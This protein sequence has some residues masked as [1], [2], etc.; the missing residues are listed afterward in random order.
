MTFEFGS[1]E[2]IKSLGEYL[3]GR[4]QEKDLS[5]EEVAEKIK[6]HVKYLAA[7]E[8]GKDADLPGPVYKE[9]FLK[10]YCEFL[11]V[12]IDELTLR[13]PEQEPIPEEE[14]DVEQKETVKERPR[15]AAAAPVV[16]EPAAQKNSGGRTFLVATLVVL[17]IVLAV[18][19]VQVYRGELFSKEPVQLPP[20]REKMP[21]PEPVINDS[22]V[23]DTSLSLPAAQEMI[24]LLMVGRGECWVE[25]SIDGDS[26]FSE[27]MKTQDTLWLAMQ[28]SIIF[29]LGRANSVDV[30]CN[31]LP[32]A[33][34]A[35][36]DETVRS[37]TLTRD[38]Y[39]NFVDSARIAP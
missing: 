10:S 8:D 1:D 38:N 25:V 26:S 17:V 37:Y 39:K 33:L 15:V 29:K 23:T 12:S 28:D 13:L 20:I 14:G 18:V 30:W 19:A 32:L 27:L 16:P 21:E 7:I 9:L 11:G 4:R 22:I 36:D 2:E 5:L 35:R 34:A 3:R 24:N 6:I 31:A